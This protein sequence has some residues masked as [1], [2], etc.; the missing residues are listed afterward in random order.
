MNSKENPMKRT[1]IVKGNEFF[2]SSLFF[3]FLFQMKTKK[4]RTALLFRIMDG[5]I[6]T[7]LTSCTKFYGLLLLATHWSPTFARAH[8]FLSKMA[9]M[10]FYPGHERV[11]MNSAYNYFKPLSWLLMCCRHSAKSNV[12][13]KMYELYCRRNCSLKCKPIIFGA[14]NEFPF[15]HHSSLLNWE[16]SWFV[17]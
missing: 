4:T 16:N 10:T 15:Y 7:L 8:W 6:A 11:R 1:T 5:K 14:G 17:V 3:A 2:H 13:I 12:I 9:A